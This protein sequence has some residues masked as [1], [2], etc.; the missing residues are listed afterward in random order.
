MPN[1]MKLFICAVL[2]SL[3]ATPGQAG[4]MIWSGR[5]GKAPRD[6]A[7]FQK[8]FGQSTANRDV[9]ISIERRDEN[10]NLVMVNGERSLTGSYSR[11]QGGLFTGGVGYSANAIGNN[12]SVTAVGSNNIIIIQSEQVNR[13]E[14]DVELEVNER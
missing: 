13:G 2:V 11:I 3:A 14:Q 7:S 8:P 5:E 10:G 6:A 1:Q 12:L 9:P 4:E